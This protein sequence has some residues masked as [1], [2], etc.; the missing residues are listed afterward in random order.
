MQIWSCTCECMYVCAC[1]LQKSRMHGCMTTDVTS[2][3]YIYDIGD[4]DVFMFIH[5]SI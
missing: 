2:V 4:I 1:M 5:I 3:C